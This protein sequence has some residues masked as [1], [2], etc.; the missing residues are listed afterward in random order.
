MCRYFLAAP[1]GKPGQRHLYRV[2][3]LNASSAARVREC[4]TCG[5]SWQMQGNLSDSGTSQHGACIYSDAHFS[6]GSARFYVHECLGPQ[7]PV[8]W[9]V[10]ARTNSRLELFDEHS[11]LRETLA[12]LS[13]PQ[14]RITSLLSLI[15]SG[16][17]NDL[18]ANVPN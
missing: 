14:V 5:E 6:P 18:H 4:L 10:E 3:D 13:L 7:P 15:V 9:L 11:A 16:R 1:E 12:E 17:Q 2:P 8:T